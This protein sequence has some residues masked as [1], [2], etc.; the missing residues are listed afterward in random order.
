MHTCQ[1]RSYS[2]WVNRSVW[3]NARIPVVPK[4]PSKCKSFP[5]LQLDTGCPIG[6]RAVIDIGIKTS[7][8]PSLVENLATIEKGLLP[9]AIFVVNSWRS[10]VQWLDLIVAH[11]IC[12]WT[13]CSCTR[14]GGWDSNDLELG[15]GINSNSTGDRGIQPQCDEGCNSSLH[16]HYC[17]VSWWYN[18]I[19]VT[20]QDQN[21]MCCQS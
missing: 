2:R 13:V 16:Y 17:S 20:Q 11:C 3:L 9:E 18:D 10:F 8:K 4:L 15:R 5:F 7:C 14:C 21:L 1:Q 19:L 6:R 12:V